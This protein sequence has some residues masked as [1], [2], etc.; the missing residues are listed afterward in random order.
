MKRK[1][2]R[3]RKSKKKS[4]SQNSIEK[5]KEIAV[6]CEMGWRERTKNS[7]NEQSFSIKDSMANL[8]SASVETK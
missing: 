6:E 3:P 1:R 7:K 8:K 4:K 5:R 2:E